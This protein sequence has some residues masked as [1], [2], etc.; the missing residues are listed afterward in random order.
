MCEIPVIYCDGE[1]N[2]VIDRQ[3]GLADLCA[4]Y[5]KLFEDTIE[6][7]RD[8]FLSEVEGE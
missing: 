6:V 8:S 2:M 4:P 7:E 5:V 3:K 1:E